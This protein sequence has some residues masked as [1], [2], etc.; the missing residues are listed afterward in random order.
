MKTAPELNKATAMATTG[1]AKAAIT[2]RI[3]LLS[4]GFAIDHLGL[5][6]L[7]IIL[8]ADF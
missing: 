7:I 8:V 4:H 3:K 5:G 6:P 2:P 1:Q